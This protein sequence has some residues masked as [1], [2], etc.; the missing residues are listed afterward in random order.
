MQYFE[1]EK[2]VTTVF[3][4]DSV[5]YIQVMSQPTSQIQDKSIP[6]SKWLRRVKSLPN[7]TEKDKHEHHSILTVNVLHILFAKHKTAVH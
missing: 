4:D 6:P 2:I 5:V 7:C 1:V 3:S